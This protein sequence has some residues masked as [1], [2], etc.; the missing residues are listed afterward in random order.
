[1]IETA[2]RRSCTGIN[3]DGTP[4]RAPAML[5]TEPATC[6]FHS[7]NPEIAARRDISRRQGGRRPR[8]QETSPDKPDLATLQSIRHELELTLQN[9]KAG[10]F[11]PATAN[12]IV[13][14]LR[15]ATEL[16][17]GTELERQV[18]ELT[19]VVNARQTRG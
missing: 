3:L 17:T 16:I 13:S 1:M 8:W 5:N 11:G 2:Q 9:L 19:E 10:D 14:V 12:S 6:W 4:C 15:Q 18:E 7:T